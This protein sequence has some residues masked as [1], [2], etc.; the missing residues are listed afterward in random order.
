MSNP[1]LE[2]QTDEGELGAPY[3]VIDAIIHE[4]VDAHRSTEAVGAKLGGEKSLVERIT[5]RVERAAHKRRMPP[6]PSDW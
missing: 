1:I 4:W 5:S 2:G 3:P 6:T